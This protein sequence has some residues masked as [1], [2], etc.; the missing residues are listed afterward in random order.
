MTEVCSSLRILLYFNL[1]HLSF[2]SR[3]MN[4]VYNILVKEIWLEIKAVT[5]TSTVKLIASVL[6]SVCAC[7]CCVPFI[8]SSAPK[9][10]D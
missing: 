9:K 1:A 5:I 2:A 10:G 3:N 8:R 6:I 7:L 4:N